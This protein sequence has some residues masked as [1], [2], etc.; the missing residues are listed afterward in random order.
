MAGV[1]AGIVRQGQQLAG[2]CIHHHH[3]AGLGLLRLHLL[4]EFLVGV[5][6]DLAVDGQLNILPIL[7][8][9]FIAHALHHAAQTILDHTTRASL[10][11]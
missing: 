11:G 3:A 10:A 1:I 6:L 9:H 5:V 2:V 7:R 8:R 4:L